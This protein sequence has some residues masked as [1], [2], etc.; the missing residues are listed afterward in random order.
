MN[1]PMLYPPFKG[2]PLHAPPMSIEQVASQGWQLLQGDLP[3]PLAVLRQQALTHNLNWMREFCRERGISLAPHGK[4]TMS[5]QLFRRQLDAG[6]WAISFATV[7]QAGIGVAHG[8]RRVFI[9]NQVLQPA[10][11]D[12]LTHL[13]TAHPDLQVFFWSTRWRKLNRLNTGAT[14]DPRMWCFP[15]CSS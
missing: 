4:T 5:P 14:I 8:V 11:L 10:D 3:L 6:A 2:Y 12:G 9:A 15:C 7:Y 1:G 13:L